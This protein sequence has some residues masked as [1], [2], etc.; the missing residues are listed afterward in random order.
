MAATGKRS[1]PLT[2]SHSAPGEARLKPVSYT[3]LTYHELFLD[4]PDAGKWGNPAT[5]GF[6]PE[7]LLPPV[8]LERFNAAL[9]VLSLIHIWQ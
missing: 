3:H 5:L 8:P 9:H 1:V 2:R 7:E 6:T 4:E